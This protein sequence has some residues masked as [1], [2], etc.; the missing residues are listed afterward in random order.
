MNRSTRMATTLACLVIP[1]AADARAADDWK[2]GASVY[3]YFPD[4]GGTTNFPATGGGSS[5]SVDVGTIIDAL[6]MNFAGTLEAHN[7]RYG[8]FTDA[9]YVNL[10]NGKSGTR[11]ISIGNAGLPAGVAANAN[12]D[13]KITLWSLAGSYRVSSSPS[14]TMDLIAGARM[15]DV[16]QTLAWEL[17]GNVASIPLSGRSGVNSVDAQNWDAIVGVKGRASFGEGNRWFVPYYADV[18]TGESNLTWQAFA[19]I[20]YDF[21]WGS[22]VA[23]W[24]YVDY[25]FKSGK[26]FESLNTS[27]P[28]IGAVFRW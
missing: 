25:D 7:G 15:L 26:N 16:S 11:D 4:V 14:A 19:G 13:L 2:F 22:V 24:R 3:G 9:Y 21:Q 27:G 8:F 1:F 18:G 10:G 23:L 28:A 5:A 20:G 6:K 17:T 12:L